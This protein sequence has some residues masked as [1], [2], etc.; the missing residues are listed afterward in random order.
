M[1]T[2]IEP[3]S[4]L[5]VTAATDTTS[6]DLVKVGSLIGLAAGD[7]AT[8]E[9]MVVHL[10]GVF[11][12]PKL[13]SDDVAVGDAL[14]YDA[15]AEHLTKSASDNT[16]AGVAAAAAGIGATTVQAFLG[17]PPRAATVT[18]TPGNVYLTVEIADLD[19]DVPAY[20]IAPVDGTISKVRTVVQPDVTYVS[21][22]GGAVVAAETMV[23]A[24][25]GSP[26]A[27]GGTAV[28]NGV[29]TIAN[30]ASI[31]EA[32]EASPT[33]NNIVAAG[34]VL[35][36]VSDGADTAAHPCTVQIE[37]TPA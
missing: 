22:T 10:M 26:V 32:D 35:S 8:G 18:C 4:P 16:Y 15:T 12:V 23:R 14:Y 20:T 28:T 6:G 3:G 27:D 7:A 13:A 19:E 36:V 31:G 24:A 17:Y 11:E 1:K 34:D 2:Y 29:V 5:T 21:G 25:L 37:I 33:A 9:A 30:G